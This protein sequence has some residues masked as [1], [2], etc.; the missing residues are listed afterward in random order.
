[1]TKE[2][3]GIFLVEGQVERRSRFILDERTKGVRDVKATPDSR[4]RKLVTRND[5]VADVIREVSAQGIEEGETP[6]TIVANQGRRV[7]RPF[8]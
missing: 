4:F 7:P 6:L 8:T 2:R 3:F 5:R 1:M